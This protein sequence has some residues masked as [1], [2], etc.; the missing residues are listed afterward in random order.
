M[1]KRFSAKNAMKSTSSGRR[2]SGA[3]RI[4]RLP[5]PVEAPRVRAGDLR[6]HVVAEVGPLTERAR[7]VRPVA[8]PVRVV[9]R[10]HDE[11][12]TERVRDGGEHGLLGLAA[13][14]DVPGVDVVPGVVPPAVADPVAALL[15]V[16]VKAVDE[17]RYPSDA[18][19]EERD[20]EP[21]MAVEDA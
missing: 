21:R 2:E 3:G 18:R 12:R 7:A 14:P 16:L 10:E 13:H 15:V 1:K 8:V 9:A 19:L 6:A 4:G 20:A 11:V 5:E 17:V